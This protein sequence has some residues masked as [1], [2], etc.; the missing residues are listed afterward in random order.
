MFMRLLG[1]TA[2][3]LVLT[4]C[5][6]PSGGSGSGSGSVAPNFSVTTFTGEEF[7]LAEHKG[8]PVV[9]NFWESW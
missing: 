8:S 3:A 4:S 2:V 7:R 9:I 1:I 5:G 6:S